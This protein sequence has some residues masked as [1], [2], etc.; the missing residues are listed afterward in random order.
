MTL[1]GMHILI[2]GIAV[3]WAVT[4]VAIRLHA[5]KRRQNRPPRRGAR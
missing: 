1:D 5:A 2:A 3:F 4:L